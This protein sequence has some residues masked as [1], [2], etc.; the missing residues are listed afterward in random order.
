MVSRDEAYKLLCEQVS[1]ENLI[2]HMLAA[3]AVMRRL[4]RHFGEDEDTWGLVGL[5]HDIDYD[6]TKDDPTRHGILG[7]EILAEKGYPAEIVRAVKA[8]NEYHLSPRE[9]RIDQALLATDPTTGLIVAGA[10]IKKERSLQ[11]IDVP[12][13]LKRM[14]E[15]SFA[16]G[17]NRDQIRTCTELGLSL[18]EFLGLSLEAMQG[19]ADK[20]G[21]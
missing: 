21:L 13:L 17:A 8:H 6:L 16:R 9:Q 18:E 10:L 4:A 7:S 15:K 1:G 19:I 12:F 11:A 14:K 20:L 2:N 5:L 3:E